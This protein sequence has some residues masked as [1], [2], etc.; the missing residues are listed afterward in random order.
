[1]PSEASHWGCCSPPSE[2]SF[3]PVTPEPSSRRTSRWIGCSAFADL[4]S[5]RP[6][7]LS[8]PSTRLGPAARPADETAQLATRAACATGGFPCE[9][10]CQSHQFRPDVR[11]AELTTRSRSSVRKGDRGSGNVLITDARAQGN[12]QTGRCGR[13]GARHRHDRT[14]GTAD[15]RARA[16]GAGARAVPAHRKDRA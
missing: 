13:Q 11:H 8:L 6:P 14:T 5:R 15:P 3:S 1:M 12:N 16:C 2:S 9:C 10:R 4:S 7:S